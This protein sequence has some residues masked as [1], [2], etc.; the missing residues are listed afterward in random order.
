M[1]TTKRI[2]RWETYN[3]DK[4][5]MIASH[6][7][8]Y[9]TVLS[10]GAK[11]TR[12]KAKEIPVRQYRVSKDEAGNVTCTCE[13][14]LKNNSVCK[15]QLAVWMKARQE[16]KQEEAEREERVKAAIARW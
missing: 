14:F 16:K 15:H 4:D 2:V 3:R 7:N 9:W 5:N 8:G 13:D 10:F 1:T 11:K 6:L 12:G